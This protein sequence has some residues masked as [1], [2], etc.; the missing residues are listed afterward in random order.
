MP[1]LYYFF[2][3][4][5]N[6]GGLSSSGQV[7]SPGIERNRYE[8]SCKVR[9][10][11][12]DDWLIDSGTRHKIER[13]CGEGFLNFLKTRV[14]VAFLIV[15]AKI[16]DVTLLVYPCF[17]ASSTQITWFESRWWGEILLN[18]NWGLLLAEGAIVGR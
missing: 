13:N 16:L 4:E 18:K 3:F 8:N 12:P 2:I 5:A 11:T 10:N 1:A 9:I 14:K 6:W 15:E 7:G 17:S